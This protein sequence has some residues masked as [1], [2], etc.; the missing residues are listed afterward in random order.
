VS[1]ANARTVL[2]RADVMVRGQ[3]TELR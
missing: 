2:E 1:Y 3:G